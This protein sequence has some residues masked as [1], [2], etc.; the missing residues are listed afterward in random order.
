MLEVRIMARRKMEERYEYRYS[1]TP[2]YSGTAQKKTRAISEAIAE[3]A[4]INAFNSMGVG[5]RRHKQ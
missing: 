5:H 4:A 3:R 2:G 1:S